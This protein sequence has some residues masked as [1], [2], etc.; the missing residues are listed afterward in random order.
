MPA[1]MHTPDL[2]LLTPSSTPPPPLADDRKIHGMCFM[3]RCCRLYGYCAGLRR[4]VRGLGNTWLCGDWCCREEI[5]GS[6]GDYSPFVQ[7]PRLSD[8]EHMLRNKSVCM[9]EGEGNVRPLGPNFMGLLI[10]IAILL[11]RAPSHWAA[12]RAGWAWLGGCWQGQ[13][14]LGPM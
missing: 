11:L 2:L 4:M 9:R 5:T 6:R 13:S 7:T 10:C 3:L 14:C 8:F 12:W 1:A